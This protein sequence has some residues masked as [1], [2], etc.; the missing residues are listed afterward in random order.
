MFGAPHTAYSPEGRV[1]WKEAEVEEEREQRRKT[2]MMTD[3]LIF[4]SLLT[5]MF[6]PCLF[7][8]PHKITILEI[9]INSLS[10][11]AR[12]P[13]NHLSLPFPS[14]LNLFL[15]ISS[16]PTYLLPPWS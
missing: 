4:P 8:L 16:S 11:S 2:G 3:L 10:S 7:L 9:T 6:F 15:P 14:F 13:S 5:P 1:V 12:Y